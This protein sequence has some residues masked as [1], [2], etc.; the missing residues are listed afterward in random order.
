MKD[1]F[2]VASAKGVAEHLVA[3]MMPT[4]DAPKPG[5][6]LCSQELRRDSMLRVAQQ[7]ATSAGSGL[8][9]QAQ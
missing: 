6:D 9:V 5:Q 2:A 3:A 7:M 8:L 4:V 1:S